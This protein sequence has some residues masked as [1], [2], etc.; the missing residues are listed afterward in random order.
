MIKLM[1]SVLQKTRSGPR[2]SGSNQSTAGY[3]FAPRDSTRHNE[4][5]LKH[6]KTRTFII[7][8]KLFMTSRY[9]ILL[10]KMVDGEI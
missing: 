3:V 2:Y 4:M 9:A 1:H 6:L 7:M 5:T 8:T 10:L